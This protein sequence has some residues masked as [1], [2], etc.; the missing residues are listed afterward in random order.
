MTKMRRSSNKEG[1]ALCHVHFLL[2]NV[3]LGEAGSEQLREATIEVASGGR[4]GAAL[5]VSF[6]W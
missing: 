4:D 3:H 6:R 5:M 1:F 2:E